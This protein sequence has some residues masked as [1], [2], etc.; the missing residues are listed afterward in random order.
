MVFKLGSAA[1]EGGP[2]RSLKD[3]GRREVIRGGPWQNVI[4]QASQRRLSEDAA[5]EPTPELTRAT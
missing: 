2:G 4:S 5:S 3:Y 1:P